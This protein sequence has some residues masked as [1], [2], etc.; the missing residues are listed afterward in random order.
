MSR[1]IYLYPDGQSVPI[2]PATCVLFALSFSSTAN[3]FRFR[4][5]VTLRA[6]PA[7]FVSSHS[8][9]VI[10]R[11]Y[12]AVLGAT[13]FFSRL[14]MWSSAVQKGRESTVKHVPMV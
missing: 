10:R 5:V 14:I 3:I 9:P 12:F 4:I 11:L 6:G 2:V 13:L 1:Y 7:E 8:L